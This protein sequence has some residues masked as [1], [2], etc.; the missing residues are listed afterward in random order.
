MQQALRRMFEPRGIELKFTDS[1]TASELIASDGVIFGGGSIL[2]GRPQIDAQAWQT[3]MDGQRPV[4]YVG[5]GMETAVHDMHH[6]LL[7]RAR[8][9]VT[10]SPRWNASLATN[11][12]GMPDLV[13]YLPTSEGMPAGK[14]LLVV[15]NMETVPT[16]LDAHWKHNAWEHFKDEFAQFLDQSIEELG[17]NPVFL[18]MCKNDRMDDRWA[19]HEIIARMKHR[20][21]KFDIIQA[22][23][24]S[25]LMTGLMEGFKVVITQRYHGIVLAQM[26]GVPHVSIDHHDKLKDAWPR[27]GI[28]IPYY[29]FA[30]QH[31][32]EA[33]KL[34]MDAPREQARVPMELYDGLASAVVD[35]VRQE[36]ENRDK[37]IRGGA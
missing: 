5:I 18:L 4:F 9:V 17:L 28:S 31:A 29:G 34:A 12:Y 36:R 37:Q 11:I 10:R 13:Y 16:H 24:D 35:I 21:T 19:A 8:A 33:C 1:I 3:L 26:A 2:Y 25:V 32:V 15:P 30:K 14:D 27:K 20:S 22:P 23:P 7:K 6:A